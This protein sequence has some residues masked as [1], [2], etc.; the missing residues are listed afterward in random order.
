MAKSEKYCALSDI[1]CSGSLEFRPE[2]EAFHCD[3]H[4]RWAIRKSWK[5]D[6]EHS[7]DGLG[8]DI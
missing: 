7:V 6:I 2:F 4:H 3:S 8:T 1:C 5:E